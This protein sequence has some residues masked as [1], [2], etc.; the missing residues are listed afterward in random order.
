MFYCKFRVHKV[1]LAKLIR[2]YG[3]LEPRFFKL[4]AFLLVFL[5]IKGLIAKNK[6][7]YRW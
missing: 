6:S 1:K 3:R 7:E 5:R 2:T 4:A